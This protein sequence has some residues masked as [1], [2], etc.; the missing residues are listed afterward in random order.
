VSQKPPDGTRPPFFDEGFE[1]CDDLDEDW[2]PP[3]LPP[4]SAE[5]IAHG[6]EFAESAER[7]RAELERALAEEQAQHDQDGRK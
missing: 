2:T 5:E 7:G 1:E 6:E 3:P 4:M